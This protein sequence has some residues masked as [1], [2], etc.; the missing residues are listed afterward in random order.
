[1]RAVE[2]SQVSRR[3]GWEPVSLPY[4]GRAPKPKSQEVESIVSHP[5][6]FAEGGAASVG[7]DGRVGQPPGNFEC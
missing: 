3:G 2:N 5:L 7:F 6:K 4:G 1:M